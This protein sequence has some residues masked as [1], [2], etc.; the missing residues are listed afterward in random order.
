MWTPTTRQQH[1]RPVT[2][3]QT[4]LTD[5]AKDDKEAVKWFRLA[6]VLETAKGSKF[7]N[8]NLA[9]VRTPTRRDVGVKSA[10]FRVCKK[11]WSY[12]G[13]KLLRRVE[14]LLQNRQRLISEVCYRIVRLLGL[15]FGTLGYSSCALRSSL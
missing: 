6:A 1:S 9:A 12:T 4:D 7:A 14:M 15:I 3:Y 13:L 11:A 5:A 8:R 2:R 10:V